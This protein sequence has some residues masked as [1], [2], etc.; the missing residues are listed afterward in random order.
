MRDHFQC[1]HKTRLL[2]L[3]PIEN[4][5]MEGAVSYICFM[6]PSFHFMKARKIVIKK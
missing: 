5:H 6:G 1:C 3:K 2:I 4:I